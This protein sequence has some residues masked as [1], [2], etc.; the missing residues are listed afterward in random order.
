VA[1]A[2]IAKG[3]AASA[4]DQL[5]LLSKSQPKSAEIFELLAQAYKN[6]GKDKEAQQAEAHAKLLRQND[7]R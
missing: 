7:R 6:L 4:L 3:K 5:N 2:Q 1:R